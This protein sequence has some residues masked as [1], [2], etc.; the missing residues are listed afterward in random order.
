MRKQIQEFLFFSRLSK[1][2]QERYAYVLEELFDWM[3]DHEIS[4]IHLTRPQFRSFLS[5]KEISINTRRLY[6]SALKSFLHYLGVEHPL[7]NITI[8]RESTPPGRSLTRAQLN[9]LLSEFDLQTDKGIRDYAIVAVMVDTGIRASEVANIQLPNFDLDD[10]KFIV[11]VKGGRWQTKLFTENTREAL[12]RWLEVRGDHARGDAVTLFV[13]LGGS[14]PGQPLTRYGIASI[15]R[16]LSRDLPFVISPHDLRRTFATLMIESGAPTRVVQAL[17]GWASILEV[18]RY[19]GN[20]DLSKL[21]KYA[22]MRNVE[23]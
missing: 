23:V 17:G 22:V 7:S 18:E 15:F 8:P 9:I 3:E 4:F 20:V 14:T 13:S 11:K 5:E 21:D 16:Y 1:R 2:T 19:T 10:R 12:E 6:L